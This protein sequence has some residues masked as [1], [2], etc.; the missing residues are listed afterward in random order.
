MGV[1]HHG[2]MF[3]L[4]K[5]SNGNTGFVIFVDRL[6]QVAHLAAVTDTIDGKGTA[7]LFIDRVFVNT[8]FLW[9]S[10]QIQI[11]NLLGGFG[12]P[13]SRC[14][15][16]DCTYPQRPSANRWSNRA[17]ESRCRFILRSVCSNTPIR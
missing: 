17:N 2:F 15:E 11:L 4:T 6:R 14:S 9:K 10:S 1:H 8:V 16:H 3:G 13:S 7:K 12:S 5:Y